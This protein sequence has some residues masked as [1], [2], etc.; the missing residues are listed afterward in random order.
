MPSLA[1]WLNTGWERTFAGK[2]NEGK[3]RP[4]AVIRGMIFNLSV[5]NARGGYMK[6]L[7]WIAL[8]WLALQFTAQGAEAEQ[9]VPALKSHSEEQ[10]AVTVQPFNLDEIGEI[11]QHGYELSNGGYVGKISEGLWTQQYRVINRDN[12]PKRPVRTEKCVIVLHTLVRRDAN[13]IPVW[14]NEDAIQIDF[15]GNNL[16][17]FESDDT[18]C[19]SS[20]YPASTVFA[21][22]LWKW[23]KKPQVG[24]YAYSFRNAWI[25]DPIAKK[26]KQIPA[27]SVSCEINEDRD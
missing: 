12:F 25:V 24:G 10:V 22:G 16:R 14:N 26:F 9:S 23:R 20:I 13:G 21:I 11:Q 5:K 19:V 27:N 17:I 3:N 18:H 7:V 6:R 8:G 1:R 2:I 4:G 15:N